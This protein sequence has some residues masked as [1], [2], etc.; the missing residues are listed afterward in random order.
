MRSRLLAALGFI[1]LLSGCSAADRE[2]WGHPDPEADDA[3]CRS[4]GLK[5]GTEPYMQ[6][7]MYAEQQRGET[8]RRNLAASAQLGALGG[9]LMAQGAQ[10]TTSSGTMPSWYKPTTQC[11]MIGQ[12][13][14]CQTY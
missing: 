5:S 7:R 6:C 14:S 10:R 1:A 2:A 4:F 13:A 8:Q 9:N 12:I 3:K 11:R